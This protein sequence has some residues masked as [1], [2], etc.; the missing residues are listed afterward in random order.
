LLADIFRSGSNFTLFPLSFPFD[1]NRKRPSNFPNF[2]Y[3]LT[4]QPATLP[5]RAVVPLQGTQTMKRREGA[6]MA[7]YIILVNMTDLGSRKVKDAT[8]LLANARQN[9]EK[10]GG[11]LKDFYLT[12][13]H[14]DGVA[15]CEAPSDEAI[16]GFVFGLTATGYIRT[17]TLKAFTVKHVE[18]IKITHLE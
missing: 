12:M 8:Q 2:F 11:K 3:G 18:T 5:A 16:L 7:N 15:V 14:I 17:T 1:S 4:K 9:L 10:E 6:E 13:G